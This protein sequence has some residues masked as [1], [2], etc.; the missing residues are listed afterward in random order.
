MSITDK[1]GFFGGFSA[2]FPFCKRLWIPHNPGN[3][4]NGFILPNKILS[5]KRSP[6]PTGDPH[7]Y[8]DLPV[9]NPLQYPE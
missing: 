7:R 3:A 2:F 4:E 9:Y 5:E 8:P 6:H 1:L